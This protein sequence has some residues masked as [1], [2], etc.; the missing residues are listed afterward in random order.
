M[1]SSLFTNT[2]HILFDSVLT[3]DHEGMVAMFEALVATGLKDFMGC[4]GVIYEDELIEFFQN[5]S[6]RD[7]MVVSTVNGKTVE[8]S[9][10]LFAE[11]FQL[12][13]EGLTDMNDVTK[14]VVFDARSV[15]SYDGQNDSVLISWSDAVLVVA[16]GTS[17]EELLCLV[18]QLGAD[19]NDGQLY[20]SLRLVSCSLRLYCSP[21]I[22]FGDSRRFRPS[23]GTFEVVLDSSRR[24]L[25]IDT[26]LGGC[27][28]LERD[29]EVAVFGR[30]LRRRGFNQISRDPF[31]DA[32]ASGD[33]ALSFSLCA[34]WLD[35][36]V[37]RL[38]VDASGNPGFTAGRGFS[39]AGGVPGGG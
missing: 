19:V 26:I 14:D 24:A 32:R 11:T 29:R 20:C 39:S 23:F 27:V 38:G 8:I 21:L 5:G 9:E 6:V 18:V 28:W 7:G 34:E 35:T 22:L 31:V 37:H 17:C 12:P 15:F 30:V 2:L 13:V 4:P 36:T 3:M 1:A 10:E 16:P 25:S 33:S